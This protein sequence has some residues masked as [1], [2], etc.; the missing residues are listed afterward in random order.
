MVWG[1]K[2][3]RQCLAGDRPASWV[4]QNNA[5]RLISKPRSEQQV[6]TPLQAARQELPRGQHLGFWEPHTTLGM[7]RQGG[8]PELAGLGWGL[9]ALLP[10]RPPNWGR[11]LRKEVLY[12]MLSLGVVGSLSGPPSMSSLQGCLCVG[13]VWFPCGVG[14]WRGFSWP[15]QQ[16][17]TLLGLPSWLLGCD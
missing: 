8:S 15:G 13:Q 5:L 1:D 12:P 16:A 9:E 2:Y 10:L 3:S 14:G 17:R 11:L 7:G 6:P 4:V